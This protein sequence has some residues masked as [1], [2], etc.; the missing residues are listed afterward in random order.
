MPLALLYLKNSELFHP[1]IRM[2]YAN[3]SLFPQKTL[4]LGS[5]NPLLFY[6]DCQQKCQLQGWFV[7]QII[8][9][10]E[11]TFY[12][13]LRISIFIPTIEILSS[14]NHHRIRSFLQPT[15]LKSLLLF[16]RGELVMHFM[17]NIE[18]N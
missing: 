6:R 4:P 8:A 1:S 10:W 18:K 16:A 15:I 2:Q 11:L 5:V 17:A 12:N 9:H 14:M 13:K 7:T 3:N